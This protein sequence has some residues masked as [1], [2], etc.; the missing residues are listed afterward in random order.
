MKKELRFREIEKDIQKKLID[1]FIEI[2]IKSLNVKFNDKDELRFIRDSTFKLFYNSNHFKS[3]LKNI[4]YEIVENYKRYIPFCFASI[5]T[6][7]R[8]VID[9]KYK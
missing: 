5:L 1:E 8:I 4:Y 2:T 6:A 3:I 7:H 9:K